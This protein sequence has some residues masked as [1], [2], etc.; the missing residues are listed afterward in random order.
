MEGE[1]GLHAGRARRD[2]ERN[3]VGGGS[4]LVHREGALRRADGIGMG[5]P[6]EGLQQRK[7]EP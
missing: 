1:L 5:R 4:L 7:N 6:R 3:G 2:L